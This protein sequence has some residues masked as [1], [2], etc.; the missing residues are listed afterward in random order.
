MT[1]DTI[2]IF[3]HILGA[4]VWVGGQ[5]VLGSVVSGLRREHRD[6]L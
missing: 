5:I 1:I 6:A 3:L 4:S 2:R